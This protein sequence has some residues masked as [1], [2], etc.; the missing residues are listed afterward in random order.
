MGGNRSCSEHEHESQLETSLSQGPGDVRSGTQ[1]RE[2][3]LGLYLAEGEGL[4]VDLGNEKD[5]DF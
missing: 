3:D 2:S 4:R 1:V 5:R